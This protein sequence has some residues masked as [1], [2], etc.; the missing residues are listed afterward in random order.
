MEDDAI[1]GIITRHPQN[2]TDM[3]KAFLLNSVFMFY[4]PISFLHYLGLLIYKHATSRTNST[5]GLILTSTGTLQPKARRQLTPK[6]MGAVLQSA[7][8]LSIK[9]IRPTLH[10]VQSATLL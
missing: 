8:V 2:F 4:L 9:V 3:A 10:T 1:A 7:W 5:A 6:H